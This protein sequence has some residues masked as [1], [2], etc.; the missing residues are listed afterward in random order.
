MKWTYAACNNI[1][2][3]VCRNTNMNLLARSGQQGHTAVNIYND[4]NIHAGTVIFK[5]AYPFFGRSWNV[6][7]FL[8]KNLFTILIYA[9]AAAV[10][11]TYS[12]RGKP[13]FIH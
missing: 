2:L 11:N 6:L 12:A 9:S 7:L 4:N 3:R 8:Q 10:A 13:I 5:C 1:H